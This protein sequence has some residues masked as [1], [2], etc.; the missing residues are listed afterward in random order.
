MYMDSDWF[1]IFC[2]RLEEYLEILFLQVRDL[3]ISNKDKDHLELFITAWLDQDRRQ[4][5]QTQVRS[6]IL[7]AKYYLFILFS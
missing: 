7:S 6:L 1:I 3:T 5:Q 4:I 2:Y